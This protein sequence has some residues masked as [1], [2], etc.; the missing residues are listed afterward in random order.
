MNVAVKKNMTGIASIISSIV[1][2]GCASKPTN[3][4]IQKSVPA[5]EK[6]A[7][8]GGILLLCDVCIMHENDYF[9]LNDSQ[10]AEAFILDHAPKY[11]ATKGY[12]VETAI[13]PFVG[14]YKAKDDTYVVASSKGLPSRD[15]KAPF[16]HDATFV[17]DKEYK[18]AL[19]NLECY[20]QFC[21]DKGYNRSARFA[22]NP[23]VRQWVGTIAGRSAASTILLVNGHGECYSATKEFLKS[24][25]SGM[26]TGLLSGGMVVVT[27][28]MSSSHLDCYAA[29]IS[30]DNVCMF[31]S[32]SLR[33]NGDPE[34]EN[35]FEDNLSEALFCH[36]PSQTKNKRGL[37]KRK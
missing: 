6:F 12:V 13:S 28:G 14:G 29:F 5:D 37:K 35:L 8:A 25:A 15:H 36:L 10:K 3:I 20:V 24:F 19:M 34:K 30:V 32:N 16:F 23:H 4:Y 21:F 22:V 9:V 11:L 18:D 27:P 26:A 17:N 31:W 7:K 2:A 1:V 33:V